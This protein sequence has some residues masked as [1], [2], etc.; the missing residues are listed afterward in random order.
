[1]S[2]LLICLLSKRERDEIGQ[3][4]HCEEVVINCSALPYYHGCNDQVEIVSINLGMIWWAL[5]S[6]TLVVFCG[7]RG[8][9]QS[10]KRNKQNEIKKR[11]RKSGM[12]RRRRSGMGRRRSGREEAEEEWKG[13]RWLREGT[14]GWGYGSYSNSHTHTHTHTHMPTEWAAGLWS[15]SRCPMGESVPLADHSPLRS[16]RPSSIIPPLSAMPQRI[17]E[18]EREEVRKRKTE[19]AGGEGE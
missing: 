13:K 3:Q 10:Q 5:R 4:S 7:T 18:K 11:T 17:T 16:T 19:K 14:C 2:N 12:G 6:Y 8:R 1:M 15:V 9:R